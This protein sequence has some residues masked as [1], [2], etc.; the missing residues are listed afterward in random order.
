[1]S[2]EV[3]SRVFERNLKGVSRK[4]QGSLKG[5]SRKMGVS[6]SSKCYFKKVEK[7]GSRELQVCF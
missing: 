4:F 5:V 7:G 3:V 1:M 2:F 6:E